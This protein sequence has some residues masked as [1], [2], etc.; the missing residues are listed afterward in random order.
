MPIYSATARN[1]MLDALDEGATTGIGTLSV[2]TAYS[3]T[4]TNEA[5]GGSP[6]YARKAVTWAPAASGAKAQTGTVTFDL[7]AGTYG[8]IGFWS[9]EATPV[10]MGMVP[11]GGAA[12]NPLKPFVMDDATADTF[13][14]VGHGYANGDSV[15]LWPGSNNTL[16]TGVA[17]GTVYFVVTTATDSFQLS[18]TSG[19]AAINV[20]AKGQGH[21]QKIVQEVFAAQGQLQV[22]NL[23]LDAGVA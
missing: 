23:S 4:G 19:G 7:A 14:S 2:H 22:S 8:W 10:F 18:A 12:A 11:N 20:T 5:T 3:A 15:V 9:T 17:E 6:A 13:R 21:A 1:R 16:P